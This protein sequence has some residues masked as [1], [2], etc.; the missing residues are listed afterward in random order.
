MKKLMVLSALLITVLPLLLC[1][2]GYRLAGLGNTLPDHIRSVAIPDFD[3][4]TTRSQLDQYITY[5]VKEEF[6][7][8]SNL[9]MENQVEDADAL[10]EGTITR[11]LVKPVSVGD[12]GS[13][14]LYRVTIELDVRFIDLKSNDILF[15][16][17]GISFSDS[18]DIDDEDFFTRE[19]ETLLE[20]V[21]HIAASVVTSVLENF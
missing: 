5:A 17:K 1:N 21:E 7:Q 14:N 4:K 16:G 13:A 20:I 10:L 12:E 18:Y 3:N 2:C 15:E 19:T 9:R 8:R 6:I 11:F